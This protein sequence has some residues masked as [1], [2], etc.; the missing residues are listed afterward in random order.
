MTTGQDYQLL[1]LIGGGGMS[2]VYRAQHLPTGRIDAVKILRRE[3]ETEELTARFRREGRAMNLLDHPNIVRVHECGTT[4]DRR[5]YIAMELVAGTTVDDELRRCRRFGV[6]RALRVLTQVADAIDH[7]HAQQVIHR[8]LKPSNL[9]LA[10]GKGGKD[11]V[12]VLDFG[13][14][15]IIA[16]TSETFQSAAD[17]V[18]GTPAYMAPEQF[19][20]PIVDGR[21]DIYA[22]GCIGFELLTGAPPFDGRMMDLYNLHLNVRP[23]PPSAAVANSQIPREVD[24]VILRCL[25]KQREARFQSGSELRAAIEACSP[26]G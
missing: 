24:D 1:E 23:P 16:S 12:R 4:P 13:V 17:H 8:D 18:Y 25:E 6:L 2:D 5:L 10:R 26:G 22:I 21:A 3:A 19:S 9:M 7:A 20:D 11:W 14:S 15:K